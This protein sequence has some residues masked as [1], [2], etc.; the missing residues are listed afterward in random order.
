MIDTVTYRF[1]VGVFNANA[2]ARHIKQM[3]RSNTRPN[4]GNI[5]DFLDNYINTSILFY[6]FY[7]IFICHFSLFTLTT[8]RYTTGACPSSYYNRDFR[9][10]IP[11]SMISFYV[12]LFLVYFLMHM[13]NMFYMKNYW[14]FTGSYSFFRNVLF[15]NCILKGKI[16]LLVSECILWLFGMN[17]VMLVLINPTIVNPGPTS[18][19]TRSLSN[20]NVYFQNVHGLIP[21]G[22]LANEHPMLDN[23]KCHEISN[24]LSHSKMDIAILNETWL[25]KSVLDSEFLHPNQYKIF[26]ADRSKKTHPPDL[27]NPSRFK[28]NG[29]GVLIAVRTDLNLSSKQIQ[30]GG[31]AEILAVEFTTGTGVKFVICTCYRVGTLGMENH[32]K[33]ISSLKQLLHRKK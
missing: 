21:F 25:K 4:T 19:V 14:S 31:G 12:R 28:R 1:R 30:L 18:P 6:I 16:G 24:Y 5:L 17:L 23:T 20:L 32:D 26:R 7:R 2:N 13:L 9:A 3:K 15:K 8:I 11:Y 29:G 27:S 33:I 10:Q 22:E